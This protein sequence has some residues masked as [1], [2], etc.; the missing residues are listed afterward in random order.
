MNSWIKHNRYLISRRVVQLSILLLFYGA[1]HFSWIILQGNLSTAYVLGAFYLSDPFAVLQMFAAGAVI[2]TDI[3]IGAVLVFLIYGIV[4]GRSFCSWVC[5][6]NIVTDTASQLRSY[7]GMNTLKKTINIS[8]IVRYGIMGLA[9]LLSIILGVA[10][11][12]VVSPI[13]M[14]HRGAVFGVGLGWLAVLFIFLFDFLILKYGWCGYLCPLGAFYTLISKYRMLKI[15]HTKENCTDC[16]ECRMICPELEVLE[17]IGRRSGKI[18]NSACNNCGHCIDV[19]D[20]DAL[21]Y[22]FGK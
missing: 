11:F 14:L 13:S 12:E 19:C 3:L 7:L 20:D 10:A 17:I 22:S 6:I 1:N 16:M 2:G 18:Q 21:K 9:V 5:P 4:L 15:Y 8:R